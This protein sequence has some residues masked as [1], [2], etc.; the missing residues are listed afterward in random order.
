MIR[1]GSDFIVG[2]TNDTWFG[3]S[4]GIHMHSRIFITRAVENRC[5]FARVANSG[6]TYIVDDYGRIREQLEVYE[7]AALRGKVGKLDGYSIYTKV[8]DVAGCWSFL[9][10]VLI[11]GILLLSWIG[12]RVLTSN[13]ASFFVSRHL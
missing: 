6:L 1:D 11:I 5:W 4:V 3:R 2:I 13:A 10:T 12:K 9:I 8:G 7:V